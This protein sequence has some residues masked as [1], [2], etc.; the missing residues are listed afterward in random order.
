RVPNAAAVP[1]AVAAFLASH[2]LP[3]A[4]V[5]APDPALAALPWAEHPLIACR[6][7]PAVETDATSLT[8]AL[9]AVAETGTLVFASGPR[10][11]S[12][13]LFLPEN[14]IAV[15]AA[16]AVVGACEDAISRLRA[17]HRADDGRLA[18]PRT[19]NMVTGPSRTGDIALKIELGAHGPRR[20]HVILIDAQPGAGGGGAA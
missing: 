18:L 8:I 19:V 7:G 9:A 13:L 15:V 17:R 16:E 2:N 6:A 12:T 14:H 3:S 11:P 20:V 10:A 4:L 5:L 1:G